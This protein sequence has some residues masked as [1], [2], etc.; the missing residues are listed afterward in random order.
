[1]PRLQ[2][3]RLEAAP[4]ERDKIFLDRLWRIAGQ[5]KCGVAVDEPCHDG[6]GIRLDQWN[7]SV[8]KK[9]F[10]I[11]PLTKVDNLSAFG[12]EH[13]RVFLGGDCP[14]K[15]RLIPAASSDPGA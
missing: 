14:Q 8:G 7:G 2:Y 9:Y 5:H 10:K 6:A 1:M 12:R 13:F 4:I 3:I 11:C 15:Y